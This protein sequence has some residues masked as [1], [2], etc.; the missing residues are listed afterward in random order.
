MTSKNIIYIIIILLL[1]GVPYFILNSKKEVT[2]FTGILTEKDISNIQK[3]NFV[4]GPEIITSEILDEKDIDDIINWINSIE[5]EKKVA[6]KD[7]GE[8]PK[9]SDYEI[10]LFDEKN[11]TVL[12]ISYFPKQDILKDN[13]FVYIVK[14]KLNLKLEEFYNKGTI[15]DK[16]P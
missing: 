8:T 12:S 14:S 4:K 16:Q 6:L 10:T 15:K 13:E 11:H 7:F 2:I 3:I 9:G 1:L 5:Y